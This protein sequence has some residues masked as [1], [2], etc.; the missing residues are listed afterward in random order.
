MDFSKDIDE[1]REHVS[2]VK[3]SAQA[4]VRESGAEVQQRIDEAEAYL[5]TADRL[6]SN[7]PI[8]LPGTSAASGL[9]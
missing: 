1:L 6:K 5:N 9:R 4:A 8:Q 7:T 2:S 3:S